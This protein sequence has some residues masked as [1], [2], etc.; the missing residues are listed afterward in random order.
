MPASPRLV[1]HIMSK[2]EEERKSLH[3]ENQDLS[4]QVRDLRARLEDYE[5][6]N[7]EL[8]APNGNY[9]NGHSENEVNIELQKENK[10]LLMMGETMQKHIEKQENEK[11][12][13]Y[14]QVE[15]LE[16]ENKTLRVTVIEA[17]NEIKRWQDECHRLKS[18]V[19]RLEE[20][21][22]QSSDL[23]SQLDEQLKVIRKM[24]REHTQMKEKLQGEI[25]SLLTEKTGKFTHSFQFFQEEHPSC[26]LREYK[27]SKLK[28]SYYIPSHHPDGIPTEN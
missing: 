10:R 27:V 6:E 3:Q 25:E 5:K 8:R 19:K 28:L 15:N 7:K 1:E 9:E 14:K 20:N 12:S 17:R 24:A 2:M 4:Q 16:G 18:I 21:D 22:N 11:M 13:L 26:Y 23:S